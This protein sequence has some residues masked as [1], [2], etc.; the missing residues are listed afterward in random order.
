MPSVTKMDEAS[1][2]GSTIEYV[3][4][5]REKMQDLEA[6]E[7]QMEAKHMRLLEATKSN[8]GINKRKVQAVEGGSRGGGARMAQV[9]ESSSRWRT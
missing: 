4:Q 3:K 8:T 6:C 2:L 7:Q 9:V 5:L 1:T